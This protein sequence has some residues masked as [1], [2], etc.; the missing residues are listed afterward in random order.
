MNTSG[1]APHQET[2]VGR[3][4]ESAVMGATTEDMRRESDRSKKMVE[5]LHA[6]GLSVHDLSDPKVY[7]KY[8]GG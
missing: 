1:L 3:N 6:Q 4:K 2:F 8:F 7:K 5:E